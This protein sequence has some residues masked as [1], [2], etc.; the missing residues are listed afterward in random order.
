MSEAIQPWDVQW[1]ECRANSEDVKFAKSEG[2][3]I[4]VGSVLWRAPLVVG[5]F[6]ADHDHWA[7]WHIGMGEDIEKQVHLAASSPVLLATLKEV[8]GRCS[9]SNLMRDEI[10]AAIKLA[11]EGQ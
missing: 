10:K 5:P 11:E 2:R 1:Y 3:R 7:G 6:A 4:K 8:L 9:M